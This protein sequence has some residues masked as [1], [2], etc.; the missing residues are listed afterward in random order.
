M[1]QISA[2]DLLS[3]AHCQTLGQ[4]RQRRAKVWQCRA[5]VWSKRQK[6]WYRREEK[7]GSLK[8]KSMAEICCVQKKTRFRTLSE[9]WGTSSNYKIFVPYTPLMIIHINKQILYQTY[10]LTYLL[11]HFNLK[12]NNTKTKRN[13]I[14]AIHLF[15]F[16]L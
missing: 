9:N 11:T 5:K 12:L 1:R 3:I 8:S 7:F 13:N 16:A 14:T 10:L 6:V 15:S 2:K 4:V